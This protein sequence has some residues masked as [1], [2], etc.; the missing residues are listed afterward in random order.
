MQRFLLQRFTVPVALA[1]GWML[2]GTEIP[3]FPA[4]GALAIHSEK[5]PALTAPVPSH[6]FFQNQ[7]GGGN[8]GERG[9]SPFTSLEELVLAAGEC[10]FSCELNALDMLSVVP[11]LLAT[12]LKTTERFLVEL[13]TSPLPQGERRDLLTLGLLTR[14][15]LQEPQRAVRFAAAH[16]VL[17][18][19]G[20]R[21]STGSFRYLAM[22]L[23]ARSHP[24]AAEDVPGLLPEGEDADHSL[25][26]I[27]ALSDPERALNEMPPD[28]AYS[29]D[30]IAGRWAHR[31]PQ[32]AARWASSKTDPLPDS[33]YSA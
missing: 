4:T 19:D 15:L 29:A 33:V 27:R 5:S 23:M 26:L 10:D 22:A 3:K 21:D 20:G 16:P 13:E 30:D 9:P 2:R 24:G 25:L 14:W 12:D 8:A 32:A 28:N 1:A 11:G 6:G 18:N 7:P 31:D 17:L